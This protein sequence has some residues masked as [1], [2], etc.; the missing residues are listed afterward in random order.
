MVE[1]LIVRDFSGIKD[2]EIDVKQINILIGP[3][4][5]GKS[6]WTKFLFYFKSFPGEIL[7]AVENEYRKSKLDSNYSTTFEE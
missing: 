4:A 5:S 3:Q 1:K 2:L 6:V 7:F